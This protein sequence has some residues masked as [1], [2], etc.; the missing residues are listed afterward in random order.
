MANERRPWDGLEKP[1]STL[2]WLSD[3][4]KD[5]MYE[6]LEK[7]KERRS[8]WPT[9][10]LS[11]TLWNHLAIIKAN[12]PWITDEEAMSIYEGYLVPETIQV[13][14]D[15]W[16]SKEETFYL[17]NHQKFLEEVLQKMSPEERKEIEKY[18]GSQSDGEVLHKNEHADS[19]YQEI[20]YLTTGANNAVDDVRIIM[21]NHPWITNEEAMSIYKRYLVLK[22]IQVKYGA[23]NTRE[24]TYYFLDNHK[25][26]EE[27][28]FPYF[29]MSEGWREE[30]RKFLYSQPT[31]T[32]QRISSEELEEVKKYLDSNGKSAKR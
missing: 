27:E 14:D 28:L 23:W 12:H 20:N 6:L 16:N 17:L 9:A 24:E 30:C 29:G 11:S 26:V 7:D 25:F 22:T 32:N 18:L 1:Q 8:S 4:Q 5:E 10:H 2:E 3:R 13:K 31:A 21:H 15:A 19:W